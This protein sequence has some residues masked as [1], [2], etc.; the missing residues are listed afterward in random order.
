MRL[1]KR[2][3]NGRLSIQEFYGANIPQYAVLSHTWG[4]GEVTFDDVRSSNQGREKESFRKINFCGR[5]AAKD[6][7]EWFWVDTCC[8]DKSSSAE[9]SE[10]INSMFKWYEDSTKCYVYLPDVSTYHFRSELDK[11][12]WFTRGWTLQ[13]LVAPKTVEFFTEEEDMIG[14][15]ASL[16]KHLQR[17]T[18]LPIE[19]LQGAPLSDFTPQEKMSWSSNR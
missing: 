8:I 10:A 11:R 15:K 5:Q 17:I 1:L 18:N 6:G 9:L 12:R 2:E 16:T 13:E 3:G 4:A 7:I 19:V 14:S